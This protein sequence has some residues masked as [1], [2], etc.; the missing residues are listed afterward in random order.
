MSDAIPLT[1]AQISS[2]EIN[3]VWRL[4][5]HAPEGATVEAFEETLAMVLDR[6]CCLAIGSG[7]MALELSLAALGVREGTEVILPAIGAATAMAATVRLGAKPVCVDVDPMSLCMQTRDAENAFTEHTRVIVGSAETGCPAGL[8][9]LSQLATRLE[10]TLLEWAGPAFGA[11]VGTESIGQFGRVT[12]FDLGAASALSTGSG[13]LIL[14]TDDHLAAQMRALSRGQRALAV[15]GTLALASPAFDAPMDDLRA[16]LGLSRLGNLTN[17]ID[18]RAEIASTYIRT[19]SGNSELILQT[20]PAN[21][22]MGWCR[23]LVRLSD[24]S[25]A[26]ERDEILEGMKRHEIGCSP[27]LELAPDSIAPAAVSGAPWAVAER[28][29]AR[30]IALPFHNELTDREIDLV[31][32]TLGLMMQRTSFG[33]DE[34][35]PF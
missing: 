1:W 25:S 3:A 33:R 15:D 35:S 30:S 14:T 21:A 29:A 8:D 7:G 10:T 19:L 27:L 18:M 31:C 5:R 34:T 20:P 4:L 2:E 22:N 11:K 16:G 13:G 6:P 26:D 12:V 24:R 17:A 23:M 32:Q 28:A 9:E